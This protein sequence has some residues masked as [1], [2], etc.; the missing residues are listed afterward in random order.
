M[1]FDTQAPNCWLQYRAGGTRSA[2]LRKATDSAVTLTIQLT[3]DT[4]QVY[5][6]PE[7]LI[8]LMVPNI[9]GN[10]VL[11]KTQDYTF[12]F[13]NV[14]KDD[15]FLNFL[16]TLEDVFKDPQ[17][18]SRK[19]DLESL[20]TGNKDEY[21]LE[22]FE[23]GVEKFIQKDKPEDYFEVLRILG[24][25]S[26]DKSFIT[27]YLKAGVKKQMFE[28]TVCKWENEILIQSLSG[29]L[30]IELVKYFESNRGTNAQ[31]L[32]VEEIKSSLFR[33]GLSKKT[34]CAIL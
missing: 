19:R 5:H 6:L 30:Q 31:L 2:V 16:K 28:T 10:Q 32:L 13:P 4:Q 15:A 14:L 25:S 11:N 17:T 27:K 22:I 29:D 20:Q 3:D 26:T 21:E 34:E 24:F 8:K 23:K 18:Q 7:K 9:L 33:Q 1:S 12:S